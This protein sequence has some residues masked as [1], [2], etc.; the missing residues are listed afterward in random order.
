[1]R[2]VG[3]SPTGDGSAGAFFPRYLGHNSPK[4]TGVRMSSWLD[5][6]A[7]RTAQFREA[8]ARRFERRAAEREAELRAEGD[9]ESMARDGARWHRQRARGER[10]RPERVEACGAAEIE[11]ECASCGCRRNRPARCRSALLCVGCRAAVG[12]EKRVRFLAARAAHL[13][14]H[15]HLTSTTRGRHRWA[16]KLL[17]LTA[18]HLVDDT[19]P[20]RIAR[21]LDGFPF[22]LRQ[23]ND[24]LRERHADRSSAWMRIYEWTPG[25]DGLGHP[26][27]H[28]WLFCPYLPKDVIDTW[29]RSA[30]N[31]TNTI[32]LPASAPL[33]TD[34]RSSE[35]KGHVAQELIK[36]LIK[37]I[38]ACGRKLPPELYAL[39]YEAFSDRRVT[40]SSRGFMKAAKSRRGCAACGDTSPP[41]VRIPG[42]APSPRRLEAIERL[43]ADLSDVATAPMGEHELQELREQLY[44]EPGGGE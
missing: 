44:Y 1:M 35:G 23:F 24:W 39:V 36:Y 5:S 15:G 20:G 25:S 32:V 33:I 31:A 40:Q 26:H 27:V 34:I 16:E 37:D 28:V 17:T 9:S 38:D 41:K 43:I 29:W 4:W 7:E 42:Q 22:F 6:V 2:G 8:R 14:E 18:P 21:V 12:V 19:V 13:D 3:Q 10:E 11:L 30:L